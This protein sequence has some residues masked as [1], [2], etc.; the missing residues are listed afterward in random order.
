MRLCSTYTTPTPGLL[1][2]H[3]QPSASICRRSSTISSSSSTALESVGIVGF[4]DAFDFDS[5]ESHCAF[6]ERGDEVA[7]RGFKGE[8][9]ATEAGRFSCSCFRF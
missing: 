6:F 2:R 9:D 8:E 1:G 3:D 5:P 4:V 7:L